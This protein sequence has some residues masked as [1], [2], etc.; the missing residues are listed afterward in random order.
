MLEQCIKARIRGLAP[1]EI[2]KEQSTKEGR[3]LITIPSKAIWERF[4]EASVLACSWCHPS[5]GECPQGSVVKCREDG[6]LAW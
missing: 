3:S 6:S 1:P 5:G 2:R 4:A